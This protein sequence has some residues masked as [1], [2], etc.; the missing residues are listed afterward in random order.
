M[1][2]SRYTT[3]EYRD[4]RAKAH[5]DV[6]AGLAYCAQPVCVMTT[7]WIPPGTPNDV[8]HDDSGTVIL[9]PAD[10]RCNRSDGG[11]RRHAPKLTRWVL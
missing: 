7:R 5:R 3:R 9:G 6:E 2:D 8:A 11:K 1:G 4:A 10:A